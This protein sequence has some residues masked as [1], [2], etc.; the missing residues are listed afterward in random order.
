ME[1]VLDFPRREQTK[2]D[3]LPD[4]KRIKC[5]T[6][7]M[8]GED[9]PITPVADSEDIAAA[10]PQELVRFERFPATGHGI[11]NDAP[12]RFIQV[13]KEFVAS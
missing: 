8:G 1:V 4:L 6:L 5:P 2:F 13:L 11:V 9:D 7:V 10:L 12:E 3:F